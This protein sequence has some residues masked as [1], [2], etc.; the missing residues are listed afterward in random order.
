M[1]GR[2]SVQATRTGSETAPRAEGP[3]PACATSPL[4][5]CAC[6]AGEHRRLAAPQRP[7]RHPSPA[8]AWHHQPM[9]QTLRHFPKPW[10]RPCRISTSLSHPLDVFHAMQS[11]GHHVVNTR[12]TDFKGAEVGMPRV[13]CSGDVGL[14]CS[15]DPRLHRCRWAHGGAASPGGP[16]VTRGRSPPSQRSIVSRRDSRQLI[17]AI[18]GRS[19]GDEGAGHERVRLTPGA[20]ALSQRSETWLVSRGGAFSSM[21]RASALR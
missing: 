4:P 6:T 15:A 3:W 9:N 10:W 19:L 12:S 14:A 21:A 17:V 11:Q 5:L 18:P 1:N 7:R 8:T 2:S 20:A 13:V 16:P